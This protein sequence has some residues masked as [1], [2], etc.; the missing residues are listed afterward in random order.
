VEL[1]IH[2]NKDPRYLQVRLNAIAQCVRISERKAR[3]LGLDRPIEIDS[4]V[5]TIGNPDLSE[6]SDEELKARFAEVFR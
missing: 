1:Y 3:L 6:L 4:T 5:T 2:H